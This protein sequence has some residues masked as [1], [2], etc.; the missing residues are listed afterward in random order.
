M[1][2][3]F[4]ADEVDDK[5]PGPPAPAPALESLSLVR[6]APLLEEAR[7]LRDECH[8]TVARLGRA[9]DASV[10]VHAQVRLRVRVRAGGESPHGVETQV[11]VGNR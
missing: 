11:N 9:I 6:L 7:S 1:Y 10:V 8:S 5:P 4:M 2:H 3:R